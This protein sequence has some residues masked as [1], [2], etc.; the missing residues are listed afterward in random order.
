MKKAVMIIMLLSF[1]LQ[2]CS[3]FLAAQKDKKRT[4][5]YTNFVIGTPRSRII[6]LIGKPIHKE[7]KFIETYD[8]C[9]PEGYER[10]FNLVAD[11]SSLFLW[12]LLATPYELTSPC[13]YRNH[14]V[15]IYDDDYRLLAYMGKD[16]YEEIKKVHD[17]LVHRMDELQKDPKMAFLGYVDGVGWIYADKTGIVC[18]P[19]ENRVKVNVETVLSLGRAVR[20]RFIMKTAAIPLVSRKTV[21]MDLN[22][23]RITESKSRLI[24]QKGRDLAPETGENWSGLFAREKREVYLNIFSS[25]CG[26]KGI[27]SRPRCEG[28]TIRDFFVQRIKETTQAFRAIPYR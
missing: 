12:E 16:Y 5:I 14:I 20:Y 6:Q 27:T 24:G 1:L 3:V 23:R 8:F 9:M 26:T 11:V 28:P 15:V 22:K 13:E 2:G 4:A 21:L 17:A 19:R 25:Y 10:G 18:D 7:S